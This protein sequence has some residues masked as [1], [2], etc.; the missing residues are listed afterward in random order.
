MT[1][2]NIMALSQNLLTGTVKFFFF[3]VFLDFITFRFQLIIM[4]IGSLPSSWSSLQNLQLLYLHQNSLSG[5]NFKIS[6][7]L[8]LSLSL[9]LL[10]LPLPFPPF[11]LSLSMF[12]VS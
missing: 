3:L 8:S 11:S 10:S 9:S 5:K 6:A 4:F 1:S 12:I 7:S 2:M